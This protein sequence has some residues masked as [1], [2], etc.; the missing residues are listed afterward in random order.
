MKTK[1]FLPLIIICVIIFSPISVNAQTS[2]FPVYIVQSG[3]TL[4]G[5]AA[6][7]GTTSEEI[8]KLN[9]ISNPNFISEGFQLFIPGFEGITGY[10]VKTSVQTTENYYSLSKTS[11]FSLSELIRLNKITSPNEIFAGS[12]LITIKDDSGFTQAPLFA[13]QPGA[14]LLEAAVLTNQSTRTISSQNSLKGAWDFVNY[15]VLY[16]LQKTE[17]AYS[18]PIN[19]PVKSID[20]SPLPIMQGKTIVIK[21]E[22]DK[23][24]TITG[25]LNGHQL[26]FFANGENEFVALQGIHRQAEIGPTDFLLQVENSEGEKFS[27]DQKVL[28]VADYF[29][30][31]NMLYVD[32][33]LMDPEI[34]EPEDAKVLALT[35]VTTPIKHWDG[36]FYKPLDRTDCTSSQFGSI[37]AYNDSAYTY[38]HSGSDF[39][40]CASNLNIYAVAPG[41]V[42]LAEFLDVRGNAVI[43]DHGWGVY[44]GYWH[45]S[46]LNVKQGDWVQAGQI[47]G[48]VGTTG[49]SNGAHL[50]L[51]VWVGGIQ[52]EP[53]DWLAK[54]YP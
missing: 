12:T 29:P 16:K 5:I 43:I 7:F 25:I 18:Y 20:I 28:L 2:E 45:Q 14:T 10:L 38:S 17:T 9:N 37:R 13:V 42:V 47:I 23:P 3:D 50:H 51:E 41:T 22:T 39:V 24:S 15:Q 31:D 36:Y 30:R 34:T 6:L 26:N 21:I 27:V 32:P 1:R 35:S 40:V 46:K 11:Q 8:I 49:R 33:R 52:V 53:L 4:N 48:E 19:S 54:V 44:S